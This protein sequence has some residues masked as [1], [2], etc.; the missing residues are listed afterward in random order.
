MI[1][2][3]ASLVTFVSDSNFVV[4]TDTFEQDRLLA[5]VFHELEDHAQVLAG[6]ASPR[7]AQ[8]AF[9]LV[10]LELGMKGVFCQQGQRQ[11][12]FRRGLW[13]LAGKPPTRTNERRGRQE[14]PFQARSRLAI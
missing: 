7:T 9:E 12:Q 3:L 2:P 10:G 14:Q 13:L 11:L 6:A 4:C 1:L 8:L 5:L